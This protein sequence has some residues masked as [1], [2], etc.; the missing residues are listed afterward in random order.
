MGSIA[1]HTEW[2]PYRASKSIIAATYGVTM[3]QEKAVQL[4][5]R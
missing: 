4:S 5:T 1:P 2:I 3:G